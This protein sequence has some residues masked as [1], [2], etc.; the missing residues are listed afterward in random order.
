MVVRSE[1]ILSVYSSKYCQFPTALHP[2]GAAEEE[3]RGA[4]RWTRGK[5]TKCVGRLVRETDPHK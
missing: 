2:A 5:A 3:A 4:K 1:Q